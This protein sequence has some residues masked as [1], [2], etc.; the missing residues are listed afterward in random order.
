MEF[1]GSQGG[2]GLVFEVFWRR[3]GLFLKVPRF[4][5]RV[6]ADTGMGLAFDPVR[7]GGGAYSGFR[8]AQGEDNRRGQ[9]TEN[10]YHTPGD[11][12]GVGGFLV[13]IGIVAVFMLCL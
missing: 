4:W 10:R 1:G 5:S 12:R 13:F 7:P 3:S 9:E 8:G 6:H 11:P 2:F